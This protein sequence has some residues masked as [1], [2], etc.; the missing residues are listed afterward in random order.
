[1]LRSWTAASALWATCSAAPG[2]GSTLHSSLPPE[3]CLP[4]G[5]HS[6]LMGACQQ[7][8]ARG[9]DAATNDGGHHCL[10]LSLPG[11]SQGEA[12][13]SRRGTRET[14]SPGRDPLQ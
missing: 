7:S 6:P 14:A 4:G 8:H 1:M 2:D 13:P 3:M 11:V 9:A 5:L 12:R 10:A